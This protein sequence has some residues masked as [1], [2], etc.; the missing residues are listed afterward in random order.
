MDGANQ[1]LALELPLGV[2]AHTLPDG[3]VALSTLH[4]HACGRR[5]IEEKAQSQQYLTPWEEKAVVNN[6]GESWTTCANKVFTF[7]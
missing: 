1:A 2:L 4:H 6:N 5:S 7:H 3:K